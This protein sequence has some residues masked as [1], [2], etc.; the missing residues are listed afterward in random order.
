MA[1]GAPAASYGS[2]DHGL[3]C[4]WHFR[5]GRPATAVD[6]ASAAVALLAAFE[7]AGGMADSQPGGSDAAGGRPDG[8][9]VTGFLW[10]HFNL[11]HAGAEPWMRAHT[12]LE[13]NFFDELHSGS[14]TTRIERDGERLFGVMN[15]VV[16]DFAFD[17]GDVATLWL[18]LGPRLFVSARRHPL[19]AIDRLRMAVR[20][21]A[22]PASTVELLDHLLHDQADELQAIVRQVVERADLMED[23][24]LAGRH[25]RHLPELPRLRRLMARLQRLLA[26]EPSALMRMLARPP[27]WVAPDD[28]AQLQAATEDFALV[29][30]DIAGVQE[31]IKLMQD[32]A[33]ARMA[34]ESNRTLFTLT[35]VT[36][37]ALP[38]NLVSGMFGMNVGGIPLGEND[39]GFWIM[40]AIIGALTGAIAW[41]VASR[42]RRRG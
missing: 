23:D 13:E 37:L 9:D 38:I 26:P 12:G 6:S 30:R 34:E 17:A 16:F 2:D 3:I 36:V 22:A 1:A 4:G 8:A 29:L 27:A 20:H 5:P 25:E 42:L 33:S 39:H 21:G 24:L 11:S 28:I 14:R 35:L 31:R 15:D 19:R 7:A 41:V 40:A 32:E 10:L 18:S